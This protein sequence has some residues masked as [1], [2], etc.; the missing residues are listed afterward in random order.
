M[1]KEQRCVGNWLK[2]QREKR[3]LTPSQTAD[4]L[5]CDRS[6]IGHYEANRVAWPKDDIWER[7]IHYL[8]PIPPKE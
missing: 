2:E 5:A 6:L 3:G 1:Q 7:I 4:I 8:L